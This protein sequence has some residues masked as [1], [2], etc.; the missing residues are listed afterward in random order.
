MDLKRRELLKV[1][2]VG[3]GVVLLPGSRWRMFG[4]SEPRMAESGLPSPYTVPFTPLRVL[5]PI[6]QE[7]MQDVYQITMRQR[8]VEI[9]PGRRTPIW[10]YEGEFPGPTI[11]AQRGR[12]V[13]VRHV[14]ELPERH[15]TLGYPTAM[16]VHLHG[17]ASLPQYDGYASDV[18]PP[19]WYKDYFYPNHQEARTLWYHDHGVHHTSQNVYQGLAGLFLIHD[20]LER[21]LPIPHGRY[22]VPLVISD[23]MFAS[24]GS[25]LWDDHDH[26]G[27]FGDV[28]LV[29]GR[30]W[31]RMQVERR[32]YRF[33]ILNA[34]GARSYRYTLSTGD[35]ITVIGTDAGLMPHPQHVSEFRHA[36]A[37]R[38][39]V[40]IDFSRYRIGQRVELRNL[41]TKNNIDY[42][43]TGR[44]MAFEVAGDATSM[45]GNTIPDSLNPDNPVMALAAPPTG[46]HRQFDLERTNGQWT[47]NKRTWHDVIDSGFRAVLADPKLGA[48]EVWEF[49]NESGGWHH[50]THVHLIDFRIVDRTLI[51]DRNE[52]PRSKPRPP[53]AEPPKPHELGP[54][55][56]LYLGESERVRVVAQFGPHPGRY[57]IHC[58]N[59]AHEDHDMMGQFEVGEGGDDPI[60]AAPARPLSE[61]PPL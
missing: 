5:A 53:V 25:L 3:A 32:K 27:V 20:P 28:I 12:E 61:A 7:A 4:T 56:T 6:R 43:N 13:R 11:V 22:D 24:D 26:A 34:S 44:V 39:E 19:G 29:N 17:S 42:P 57:M 45:D 36:P 58:H 60:L 15:P 55:D 38:Y 9:L 31:P 18:I 52:K 41:S 8:S 14:N 16:S 33:R 40:V 46:A 49:E 50:P 59:L 54:K 47:I 10:G 30:P 48:V 21:S 37:E 51:V 23:A 35:P 1:G 2:V